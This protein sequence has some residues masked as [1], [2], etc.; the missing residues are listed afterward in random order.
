MKLLHKSLG[1]KRSK[2][3]NI[4]KNITK[5]AEGVLKLKCFGRKMIDEVRSWENGFPPVGIKI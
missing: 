4:R 1:G 5:S 2:E 3:A